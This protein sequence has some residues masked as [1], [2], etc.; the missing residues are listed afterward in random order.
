MK[1]ATKEIFIK[2]KLTFLSLLIILGM[3]GIVNT[4]YNLDGDVRKIKGL[5]QHGQTGGSGNANIGGEFQMMDD[6]GNVFTEKNLEG[7][8]SLIFFGYTFCPDVC[9]MAM[10]LVSE[11]YENLPE[12]VQKNL[13]PIMV[14]VDPERDSVGFMHDYVDAFGEYFIG[15]TGTAEQTKDMAKKYLVYYAKVGEDE[16]YAMSHSGYL[17][18]MG[19]DG[20]YITHFN[21]KDTPEKL[22]AGLEAI[23]MK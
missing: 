22:Q 8:F 16:N 9:P 21:H 10:N 19:P 11:A 18:L 20:K 13:Q 4:Y 14:T 3:F 7:K 17:Y 12:Y 15:L 1:R 5:V 2:N 6:N 23:M